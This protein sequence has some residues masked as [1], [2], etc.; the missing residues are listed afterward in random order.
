MLLNTEEEQID[1]VTV[2][3]KRGENRKIMTEI[4]NFHKQGESAITIFPVIES[5]FTEPDNML[6]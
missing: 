3:F 1:K 5:V 6:N 2:Y 4:V